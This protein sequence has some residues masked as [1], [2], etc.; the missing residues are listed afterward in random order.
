MTKQNI[1]E[2]WLISK[3]IIK[4]NPF[5]QSINRQTLGNNSGKYSDRET[6]TDKPGVTYLFGVYQSIIQNVMALWLTMSAHI[7]YR[8]LRDHHL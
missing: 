3:Q 5:Q 8:G 7:T 6:Y 2:D 1:A 4:L